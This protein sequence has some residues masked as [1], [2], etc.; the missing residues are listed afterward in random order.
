MSPQPRPPATSV[1]SFAADSDVGAVDPELLALPDPPR[2]ERNFTVAL[3]AVTALVSLV[4]CAGLL[5]DAAYAFG[6]PRPAELGDLNH[7]VLPRAGSGGPGAENVL[8]RGDGV[9]GLAGA[10][11]YERPF[12]RDSYRLVPMAGRSDLWVEIRVPSGQESGRFVPPSSFEGRLVHFNRAGFRHRGLADMAAGA[13]A[14]SAPSD[15]PREGG[16][17]VTANAS[18]N[19]PSGDA[20]LL[21]DGET[22]A[23]ASWAVVLITLFLGFAI[24]NVLGVVRFMRRV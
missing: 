1:P 7:V 20:W 3:L 22:P 14:A 10:I 15:R 5:Q 19:A 11:R 24:W 16:S 2:R 13:A 6:S 17:D 8:V 18:G 21:V 23:R 9:V 12:E 4:M